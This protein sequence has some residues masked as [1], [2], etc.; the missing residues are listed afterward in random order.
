MSRYKETDLSRI[1]VISVQDRPSKVEPGA[2]ARLADDLLDSMPDIL[3][4]AD[5]KEFVRLCRQAMAQR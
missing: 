2:F 5:F 3:K 4:G 1:K